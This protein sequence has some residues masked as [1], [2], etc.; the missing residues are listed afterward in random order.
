MLTPTAGAAWMNAAMFH[1]WQYS[2]ENQDKL[3]K[4]ELL[5]ISA[6][7]TTLHML[8]SEIYKEKIIC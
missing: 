3:T 1:L 7:I 2:Y 6:S 8:A 4:T 5:A